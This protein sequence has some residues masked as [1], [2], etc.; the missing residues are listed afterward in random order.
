MNRRLV[1]LASMVGAAGMGAG[2]MF[3]LDPDRGRRRRAIVRQKATSAA[4]QMTDAVVSLGGFSRDARNRAY[5]LMAET[6]SRL[7]REEVDDEVL[8]ARV[9]ARM[10]HNIH[11]ADKVKVTADHGRVTLAGQVV[12]SEA[13][14]LRACV[15]A[16]R[17]VRQIAD[18][19]EVH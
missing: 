11:N 16:V 3:F 9:R 8:E 17:G 13:E 5:G 10:G 4:S 1:F 12:A 14:A 7:R 19:T 15:A 2:M 6:R 18:N